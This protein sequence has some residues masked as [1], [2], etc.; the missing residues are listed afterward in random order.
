ML[1]KPHGG[2]L[3]QRMSQDPERDRLLDDVKRLPRLD[4]SPE[5]AS[6]VWNLGIG[7]FSPL[8]GF[9]GSE[10]FRATL[11]EKRLTN[12]A[13]WTIPIVLDV[14]AKQVSSLGKDVGLW[15]AGQPLALLSEVSPY[16]YDRQAYA[17]QVFG[18]EDRQASWRCPCVRPGGS[19][20][21]GDGYGSG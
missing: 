9:M 18:T 19:T 8:E 16:R 20:P 5:I 7:A 3:I 1:S 2:R 6:D 12:G 17:K 11:Y 21:G 13:P 10:D 4:I 14:S 15:Y